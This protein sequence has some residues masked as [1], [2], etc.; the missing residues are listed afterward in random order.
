MW[1]RFWDSSTGTGIRMMLSVIPFCIY[2][3]SLFLRELSLRT[4]F[5][6]G[7]PEPEDD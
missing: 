1:N 6:L 2:V 7:W 5:L 3:I 4:L